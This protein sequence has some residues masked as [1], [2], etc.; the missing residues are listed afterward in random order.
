[1]KTF[2]ILYVQRCSVIL[3]PRGVKS[4]E[5]RENVKRVHIWVWERSEMNGRGMDKAKP[6]AATFRV[7]KMRVNAV[8]M[9][10]AVRKA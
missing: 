10:L 2:L 3:R 8:M 1:M 7:P 9:L 6:C 5:R 4:Q